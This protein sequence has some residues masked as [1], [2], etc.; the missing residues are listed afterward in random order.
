M[1]CASQ[2]LSQVSTQFSFLPWLLLYLSVLRTFFRKQVLILPQQV[3]YFIHSFLIPVIS[4]RSYLRILYTPYINFPQLQWVI[5][6]ATGV[7]RYSI[8]NLST[9]FHFFNVKFLSSSKSSG[10]SRSFSTLQ[11]GTTILSISR[12]RLD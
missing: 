10:F 6:G 7:T 8:L 9:A 11:Q 3:M 1:V 4:Y 5:I 12:L 2:V